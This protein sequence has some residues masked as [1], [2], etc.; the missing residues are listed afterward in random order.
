MPQLPSGRHV[1]VISNII[2]AA[3]R[4]GKLGTSMAIAMYVKSPGE[5]APL[6]GVA[7]YTPIEGDTPFHGLCFSACQGIT[8]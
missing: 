5:M 6:I 3:V 7:Y 1:A 2:F 8:P 4:E